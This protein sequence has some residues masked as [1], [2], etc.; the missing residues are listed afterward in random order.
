MRKIFLMA[1]LMAFFV[2]KA[3]AQEINST[4]NQNILHDFQFY[5]KLNRSVYDTKSK[6]HSSIRGFYADDSRLKT[7]YDSV[8]NYGVDTLNRRSWVHRKL[9]KEHLIEFK[10][11]EYSIYADFLPDFQIGKDIEGNRGT[12]LN[13]RGFQ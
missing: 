11:E 5:Q 12:W 4:A 2:L 7:S 9:F 13:T 6:F 10:N 3:D 8:M 1:S